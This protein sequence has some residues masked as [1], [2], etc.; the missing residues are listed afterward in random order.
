MRVN[1]SLLPVFPRPQPKFDRFGIP[2]Y[3]LLSEGDEKRKVRIAKVESFV[4][5]LTKRS[6]ATWG[7]LGPDSSL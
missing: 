3:T 5:E 4:A 7:E 1:R 2:T 6:C